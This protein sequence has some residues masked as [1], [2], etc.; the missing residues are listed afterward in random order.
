M[1]LTWEFQPINSLRGGIVYAAGDTLAAAILQD[2]SWY[3]MLGMA[4]IGATVYAFEV[5]NYFRWIARVENR[6][7][8]TGLALLYFNPLW[9]ARHLAFVAVFSGVPETI[10]WSLLRTAAYS[11]AVNIPI[12][13]TGN[14][15]IQ[16]KIP[17]SWRFLASAV[18][19]GLMALYYALSAV[20]FSL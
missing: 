6:W 2:F 13:L 8:R 9:V 3:R 7:W 18:F 12:S 1:R 20:W 4:L 15:I 11:F 19:S 16:N 10:G 14:Y 17:L 5:P